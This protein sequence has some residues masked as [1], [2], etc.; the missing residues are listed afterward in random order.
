MTRQTMAANQLY[1]GD[2]HNH[3][4]LGYGK[5]SLERSIDIARSHL[6]FFS[7]TGHSSW[8][9]MKPM[10]GGREAHWEKGF[11]RHNSSWGKIRQL[12][13]AANDPGRFVSIL[14][15]EW[16]SSAYGDHCVY[17]S[18]DEGEVAFSD[19]VEELRAFCREHGALMIPH[20]LAYPPGWRGVNWDVFSEECSPLVEIYSEHGNSE[21]DRGLYPFFNHSLGGRVTAGTVRH[22]L[23]RGLKFGFCASSDSHNGFPGGHGEGVTGCWA[24]RLDR[25]AVLE[26]IRARRT[27]G[28][29][30]DRIEVD[31]RVNGAPMG[32][33]LGRVETLLAQWEVSGRDAMDVVELVQDGQVVHRAFPSAGAD[34]PGAPGEGAVQLR[35]EWGWGPWGDL[36][37]DRICDWAFSVEVEGGEL[38]R[39]FRH[40]RS[41][42]FDEGRRHRLEHSEKNRFKVESYSARQGAYRGNPNHDVVLEVDG[43]PDTEVRLHVERPRECTFSF[44]LA[45]LA[46][47]GR[48]L[49]TGAFPKESM[50]WHRAVRPG[51]SRVRGEV[52]LKP[53]KSGPGYVYLRGRQHNGQLAWASPVFYE[54]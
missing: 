53:S 45:E 43:T 10:E 7:F 8:H 35:L 18:G 28:L 40:W 1:F 54:S 37:L 21:E 31:F 41:G 34:L 17:F 49:P 25:E 27:Y 33:D 50:L 11:A 6:D 48:F 39:V 42:P 3:N 30:G 20:H 19:H 23:D 2:I 4:S 14:A 13:A 5:G 22:A 16:H 9:D 29:T 44:T 12:M 38:R 15:F 47:E 26:A 51:A 24:E 52:S 32:A 36:A 46:E